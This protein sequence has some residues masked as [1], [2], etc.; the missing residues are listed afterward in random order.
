VRWSDS[1]HGFT[2]IELLVVISIITILIALLLPSL[3]TAREAARRAICASNLRQLTFSVLT[4][5][6]DEDGQLP[7]R[8]DQEDY[9]D[10]NGPFD[11]SFEMLNLFRWS[12]NSMV[13]PLRERYGLVPGTFSDPSLGLV[14]SLEPDPANNGWVY[15]NDDGPG[16]LYWK[17]HYCYMAGTAQAVQAGAYGGRGTFHDTTPTSA[18]LDHD[19]DP[20]GVLFSC[21]AFRHEPLTANLINHAQP[22]EP[23]GW[24]PGMSWERMRSDLAGLNRA[25]LGGSVNWVPQ[26]EGIG[27]DFEFPVVPGQ[28]DKGHYAVGTRVYYW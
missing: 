14:S 23:T 17:T 5:A 6:Q 7:R 13:G 2:L 19:A 15:P 1:R 8:W 24:L 11:D 26:D 28:V 4:Y 27:R 18:G 12:E 10:K 20:N 16:R 22:G 21:R 9:A 3:G 25:R